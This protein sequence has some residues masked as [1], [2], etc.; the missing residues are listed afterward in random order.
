ME[1]V[2]LLHYEQ[3]PDQSLSSPSGDSFLGSE[4]RLVVT[5]SDLHRH[6]I[7]NS[8]ASLLTPPGRNQSD[9]MVSSYI[10]HGQ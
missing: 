10:S 6:V 8:P 7:I 4:T 2:V 3:L 1:K 9:S 5:C